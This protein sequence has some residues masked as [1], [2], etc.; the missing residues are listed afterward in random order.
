MC[1]SDLARMAWALHVTLNSGM[2]LRRAMKMSIASTNNVVYTQHIDRVLREI[3]QG[4]S[5]YEALTAAGVFPIEL[6][7]SVQVGEQSGRLVESMAH[8]AQQYQDQA[9]TA[10]LVL[11]VLAG[12]AATGLIAAVIVFLIFRLFGFYI[13]TINEALEMRP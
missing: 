11:T 5:I 8:M 10:M 12:L 3:R 9:R 13:G 1:S 7:E 4:H 6:L 2:D